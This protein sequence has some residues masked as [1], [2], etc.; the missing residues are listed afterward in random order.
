MCSTWREFLSEVC[1]AVRGAACGGIER[2][3]SIQHPRSNL[4]GPFFAPLEQSVRARAYAGARARIILRRARTP[5]DAIRSRPAAVGPARTD[6]APHRSAE[7][8]G[9]RRRLRVRLGRPGRRR[10]GRRGDRGHRLLRAGYD[11]HADSHPDADTQPHAHP[12][13]PAGADAH[14]DS[15]AQ[16]DTDAEA[17]TTTRSDPGPH[18]HADSHPTAAARTASAA[19]TSAACHQGAPARPQP[20]SL[21]ETGTEA[22]AERASGGLADTG[23]LPAVPAPGPLPDQALRAVTRLAH[24]ARHRARG[25]RR[26]RP[27][28]ALI[29]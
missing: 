2:G 11:A 6:L 23:E 13:V 4:R 22:Q 28:P 17:T 5:A 1:D 10:R 18:A 15:P 9:R 29:R 8:R 26:R 7:R 19:S 12:V 27:A 25:V 20:D 16:A 14:P 24:P 3:V 21:A